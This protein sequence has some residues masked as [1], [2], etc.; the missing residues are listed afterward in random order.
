MQGGGEESEAIEDIIR[1]SKKTGSFHRDAR[2]LS[3]K[4]SSK[5]A[6]HQDVRGLCR[7]KCDSSCFWVVNPASQNSQTNGRGWA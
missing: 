7:T 4:L 3:H 2:R 6:G 1:R 5:K